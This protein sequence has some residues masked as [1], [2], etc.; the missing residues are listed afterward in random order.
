MWVCAR[1]KIG[2]APEVACTI[3]QQNGYIVRVEVS[4]CKVE[5]AVAVEVAQR[6]GYWACTHWMYAEDEPKIACAV[7]QMDV[8]S[9]TASR[10]QSYVGVAVPIEVGYHYRF[11]IRFRRDVSG[12]PERAGPGTQHDCNIAFPDGLQGGECKV[13]VTVPV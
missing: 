7:S 5:V 4:R 13:R 12:S 6:Y 8:Y 10:S 2:G 9:V 3:S 11:R 1:C